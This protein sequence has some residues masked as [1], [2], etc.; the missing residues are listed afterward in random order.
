MTHSANKNT[1]RKEQAVVIATRNRPEDLKRTLRSIEQASQS[2]ELLVVV[3]DASDLPQAFSNQQYIEA[4]TSLHIQYHSFPGSPAGTRQRNYGVDLLPSSVVIVH[5]IDDDVEVHPDYF[6]HLATTLHNHPEAGGVGGYITETT[7]NTSN[8]PAWIR[9]L[10][11]IE[12]PQIG[13]VLPSGHVSR[14]RCEETHDV[15]PVDWLSTCAS[16]YRRDV[17]DDYQFDPAAEGPSPRLEDLDFSYRVSQSWN[18]LFQPRAELTHY[19]S[20]VNRRPAQ[21]RAAER[22]ARRYWFVEKTIR[23][24]LRKPAFWWATFG[25]ALAILT[26]SKD[27][28]WDALRGHLQGIRTVL[29]RDHPLLTD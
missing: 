26:S 3:V 21:Q 27:H 12:S 16:S 29:M 17:F 28:K 24:P 10:F 9:R 2:D 5:F 6:R 20:S 13:A 8:R 22:I 19:P 4:H 18:L 7:S 11:L 14:C 25:Q 1:L 15:Y 23:H